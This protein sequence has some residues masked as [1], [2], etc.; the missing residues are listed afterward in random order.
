MKKHK[1]LL[2]FLAMNLIFCTVKIAANLLPD[3]MIQKHIHESM[4]T[5]QRAGLYPAEPLVSSGN[6]WERDSWGQIDFFTEMIM[7]NGACTPVNSHPVASAMNNPY[8]TVKNAQQYDPLANLNQAVS[9]DPANSQMVNAPQYWWGS[10]AVL[11]LFLIFFPYNQILILLKVSFYILMILLLIR[12]RDAFGA[13]VAMAFAIAM[14]LINFTVLPDMINFGMA[15]LVAFVFMLLAIR[16]VKDSD[17][18]VW[19]ML[20][21]G[22]CTAFFDWLSTPIITYVFVMLVILMAAQKCGAADSYR[23]SIWLTFKGSLA[24]ALS[25]ACTLAMKWALSLLFLGTGALTTIFTRIHEDMSNSAVSTKTGLM[26]YAATFYKTTKNLLIFK[27]NGGIWIL[28]ALILVGI[29][30]FIKYHHK[31][32]EL[33]IP[34][35]MVAVSVVPYLWYIALKGHSYTHFWFTYRAIGGTVAALLLAFLYSIEWSKTKKAEK[36]TVGRSPKKRRGSAL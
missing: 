6:D 19:I 3:E 14:L 29:Y 18:A 27:I 16:R 7:V 10:L 32:S 12:L 2:L 1:I 5:I 35:C 36:Q 25:Y 8:T 20:L 33:H 17:D 22:G 9:G 15:F 23:S 31:T 11:R 4:T 13:P 21:T 26:Y 24:W 28:L 34:L 30:I